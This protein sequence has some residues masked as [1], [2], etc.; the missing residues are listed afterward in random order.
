MKKFFLFFAFIGLVIG[1]CNDG[2]ETPPPDV[3]SENK[4]DTVPDKFHTYSENEL[5]KFLKKVPLNEAA[6]MIYHHKHNRLRH[7]QTNIGKEDTR[8]VHYK[9]SELIAYLTYAETRLAADSVRVYFGVHAPGLAEL[10][11]NSQT[12]LF[13]PTKNKKDIIIDGEVLMYAFDEGQLCPPP[14]ANCKNDGAIIMNTADATGFV[15]TPIPA[16]K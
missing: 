15:P 12:I 9:I 4:K 16:K 3:T 11:R 8:F 13:I 1:S 2:K 10:K 5:M 14:Y 6:S 7:L